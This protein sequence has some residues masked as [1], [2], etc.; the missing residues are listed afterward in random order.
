MKTFGV[1]LTQ[2]QHTRLG[3]LCKVTGQNATELLRALI[4]ERLQAVAADPAT[5]AKAAALLEEHERQAQA[6]RDALT[7][8]ISTSQGTAKTARGRKPETA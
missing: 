3:L 1:R 5:A 8:L 7:S 2:E 4:E 6:E